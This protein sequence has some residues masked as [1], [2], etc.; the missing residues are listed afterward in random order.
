LKHSLSAFW[1]IRAE[2]DSHSA[3]SQA[4]DYFGCLNVDAWLSAE[5]EGVG[6]IGNYK[7]KTNG[8]K[9]HFRPDGAFRCFPYANAGY[10]STNTN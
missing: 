1:A 9:L 3:S 7:T 6:A 4:L 2:R 5:E 10:F 8:V